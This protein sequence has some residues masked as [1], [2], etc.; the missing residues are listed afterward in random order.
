MERIEGILEQEMPALKK[1]LPEI[2]G[3]PTYNGIYSLS[4]SNINIKLS[5]ECNEGDK[6]LLGRKLTRQIK[7][8]FDRYGITLNS[9]TCS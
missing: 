1:D 6:A 3:G 7:V 4:G 8:I 9:V 5:A 2:L